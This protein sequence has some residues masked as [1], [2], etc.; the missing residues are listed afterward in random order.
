MDMGP[1]LSTQL[2]G[3]EKQAA[4]PDITAS[5]FQ[6][7]FIDKIAAVRASTDGASNPAFS[8]VVGH[9]RPSRE[10]IGLNALKSVDLEEVMRLISSLPNKQCRSDPLPTW[11]LKECTAELA[12]FIRRLFNASLCSGRVPQS[13]KSA[14]SV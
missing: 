12:P 10:D 7:F 6:K 3:R 4:S 5:D 13:F 9:F 8:G 11:L 14:Y 1:F 2:M